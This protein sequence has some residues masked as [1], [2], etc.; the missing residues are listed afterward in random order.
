[1]RGSETVLIA[2]ITNRYEKWRG[3]RWPA[4][5]TAFFARRT[6]KKGC[7]VVNRTLHK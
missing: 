5:A 4:W 1:M 7:G 3:R 6:A 2:D